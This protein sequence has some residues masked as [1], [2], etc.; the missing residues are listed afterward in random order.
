MSLVT[1]DISMS[2]DGFVTGPDV[3]M[4][5]AM[6][7]GGERLHEWM[8]NDSPNQV[9]TQVQ[10]EIFARTG[11]VILGRRTFDLGLQHW[12]DTPFPAPSFVIT[13][14][15]HEPL[16]QKS[17][18]FVF[19]TDGIE[20]ALAQARAAAGDKGI[21]LMGADTVQQ[22]LRAGLVDDFQINLIP[23]LFGAGTRL[24][25]HFETVQEL[26]QVRVLESPRATHIKFR[27]RK[28]NFES[29]IR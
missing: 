18:S 1:F 15:P 2:L 3:S 26:E 24:F 19:V 27:V 23:V 16:P 6:G 12:G 20:S 28:G 17:A 21:R 5:F 29:Q 11:A 25:E 13:H 4:E 10:N 14:R 7:M 8:F 9:D 22:F